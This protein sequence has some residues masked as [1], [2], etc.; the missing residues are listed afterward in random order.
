M[1]V[2]NFLCVFW[3]FCIPMTHANVN[4][5][6]LMD[7]KALEA[8]V[9][10]FLVQELEKSLTNPQE[11]TID[12]TIRPIDTRL[13]LATCD[14]NLT[15]ERKNTP[16]QSK[17]SI[18]ARCHGKKPWSTFV[19]ANIS[20][21]QSI[22]VVKHELPRHH[23]L[24]SNDLTRVVKD[25]ANLRRGY[26]TNINSLVGMQLK[27]NARANTVI[28]DFQLQLPDII[29][30]GDLVTVSTRRGSL[31][32]SSPGIAMNN[33]HKGEKIKVENRRSSRVIQG[34]VTGPGSVE[35]LL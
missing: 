29:K 3:Y 24:S 25:I 30:K 28:Y 26:K 15:F 19:M 10:S 35:V 2:V 6:E 4:S 9:K 31:V 17:T 22:V 14:N 5:N 11:T 7:L 8:S 33:G 13:R 34:R 16:I 23:I 18:R 20:L 32:V 1:K 27:R 12:I 21:K